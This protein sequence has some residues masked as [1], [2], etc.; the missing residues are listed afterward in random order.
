MSK[1]S[2]NLT[3]MGLASQVR[4]KYATSDGS[5]TDKGYERATPVDMN[6]LEEGFQAME[7]ARARQH[8]KDD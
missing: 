4:H 8:S 6:R 3:D 1:E 7:K 2:K 5:W